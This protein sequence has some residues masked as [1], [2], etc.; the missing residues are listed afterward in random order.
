M[1]HQDCEKETNWFHI[2]SLPFISVLFHDDYTDGHI[3]E[4]SDILQFN[5]FFVFVLRIGIQQKG[6]VCSEMWFENYTK[7][8]CESNA[9]T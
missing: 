3:S 8:L 6:S 4:S 5:N 9:L 7:L 2:W 1:L